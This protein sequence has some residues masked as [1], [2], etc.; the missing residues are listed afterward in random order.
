MSKD[1]KMTPQAPS[2]PRDLP[3][4]PYRYQEDRGGASGAAATAPGPRE[5]KNFLSGLGICAAKAG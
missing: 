3:N 2:L 4:P 1:G 5:S